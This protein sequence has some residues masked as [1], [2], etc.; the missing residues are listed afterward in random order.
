MSFDVGSGRLA[1]VPR[2]GPA[3]VSIQDELAAAHR[4]LR[5]ELPEVTRVAAALYD[6]HTD[7]LTTFVN[8]TEGSTPLSHYQVRVAEVPSL[9][10]LAAS[11]RDRVIDD[12][13]VL[14]GSPSEHSQALLGRWG[15]SFT[16]PLYENGHLR[17]FLFFDAEPRAYFTP[18]VVQRLA[19]FADF[20][21]LLLASSLFPLRMLK[22]AVQV[23]SRVTHRRDPETGAHLDRM[24]H[25]A[26]L[27]ALALAPDH[28]RDDA[29]V[30]HVFRF[31]PLHDIGK[32]AI[33]DRVLLKAGP[34]TDEEFDLMKT[35]ALE[36]AAM[37][38]QVLDDLG[39]DSL[40]DAELLSH[41]VRY[42]HE[43]FDGRGYPDGLVGSD[44]PLEARIVAVA[45]V[46]DALTSARPYKEAWSFERAFGYL[47]EQ[48]GHH[49]DPCCVEALVAGADEAAEIRSAF[50]DAPD[51][52]R[53]REGYGREL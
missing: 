35:H 53:L 39:A 1:G 26:R 33:P 32:V 38:E 48:A 27:I 8:S 20:V 36:G 29:W 52:T 7:Q 37:I 46:F 21:A 3:P 23:A 4:H 42:H 18:A 17:G 14:A 11:G 31:A 16:R 50:P 25:Y 13:S 34:L 28:A 10:E 24:A 43:R 22:S 2:S 40:P 44:I 5:A 6:R 30:E 45:D 51:A 9:K 47:E 49:F 19:V 41:I 12:L 15:S